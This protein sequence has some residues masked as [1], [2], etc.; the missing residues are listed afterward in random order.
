MDVDVTL[1]LR[2]GAT[3][4]LGKGKRVV[5]LSRPL[6]E[7]HWGRLA[8]TA[9]GKRLVVLSRTKSLALLY[10]ASLWPIVEPLN[11]L[12]AP[13]R[14]SFQ[15]KLAELLVQDERPVSDRG[16]PPGP[17]PTTATIDEH[18]P[19]AQRRA[20]V[21]ADLSAAINLTDAQTY[22]FAQLLRFATDRRVIFALAPTETALGSVTFTFT[23]SVKPG[24]LPEHIDWWRRWKDSARQRLRLPSKFVAFD[25]DRS[26]AVDPYVL[27]VKIPAGLYVD[28]VYVLSNHGLLQQLPRDAVRPGYLSWTVLNGRDDIRVASWRLNQHRETVRP[29]VLVRMV[30][31]PPGSVFGAFLVASAVLL[32]V[33]LT[34]VATGT[35]LPSGTDRFNATAF[36]VVTLALTLPGLLS[37]WWGVAFSRTT[38]AF[39]SLTGMVSLT[40]SAGLSLTTLVLYVARF[41]VGRQITTTMPGNHTIYLIRDWQSFTWFTLALINVGFILGLFVSRLWRY[42]ALK[43]G[44]RTA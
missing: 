4:A 17:G 40:V 26:W 8:A 9:D 19:R 12:D 28:E 15:D 10:A 6:K 32:S 25:M 13:V 39:R 41:A 37:T 35:L 3:I 24:D 27:D 23:T 38:G 16:R 20:E 42:R 1:D 7:T 5:V 11:A 30:E 31:T 22:A 43:T 14:E 21:V 36:G 34:G 2:P 44:A 18:E 33:W 29:R